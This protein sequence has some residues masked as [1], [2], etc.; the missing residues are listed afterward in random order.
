[1][2]IDLQKQKLEEEKALLTAELSKIARQE[3][4][5]NWVAVPDQ[6]DGERADELDNADLTEEYEERIAILRPLE[7]QYIQVQKALKAIENGTYGTCEKTGKS[8]SEKRLEAYPAATTCIE[9][10]E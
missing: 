9:A 1:M 8:I 10:A 4:T 6:G 7:T 5:G 2:N 3:E